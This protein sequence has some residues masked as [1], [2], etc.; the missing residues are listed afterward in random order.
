[1]RRDMWMTA[2]KG[3]CIGGSMTVPG[4]SGGSMAMILGI[5]DRLISSV[6]SLTKDLRGN[7]TF[8]VFFL[9]GSVAGMVLF[10][11]PLLALIE[12]YPK[13]MLFFFLGAVAGGVP[14]ILRKAQVRRLCAQAVIYPLSGAACVLALSLLPAGLVGAQSGFAG[15]CVE[16]AAGVVA[17][18]ALVLPGIS[19]SYMLLMMGLYDRVLASLASLNLLSLLPL[20]LGLLIGI[21]LTTRALER[22]MQRHPRPT[23]LIILGFVLGSVAE[24]FPGLPDGGL[25]WLLCLLMAAGGYSAIDLIARGEKRRAMDAAA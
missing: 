3:V 19:V 22:A 11:N 14:M 16:V 24:V 5:Y 13:P 18:V 15:F 23:Y 9:L 1:M 7:L 6:S 4:V 8:L 12:R 2:L 10:A 21:L 25:Q 17:A 20:A